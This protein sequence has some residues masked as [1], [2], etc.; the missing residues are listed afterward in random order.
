MDAGENFT[1]TQFQK[2]SGKIKTLIN[3][4]SLKV[5]DNMQHLIVCISSNILPPPLFSLNYSKKKWLLRY[6][7]IQKAVIYNEANKFSGMDH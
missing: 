1:S 5:N 4:N 7:M 3:N 2:F 6:L